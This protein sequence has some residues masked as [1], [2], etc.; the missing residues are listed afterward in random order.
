MSAYPGSK[1]IFCRTIGL[2]PDQAGMIHL[3]S[4]FKR[5][6]RLI[7][8]A[9]VGSMS[10]RNQEETMPSFLRFLQQN[11]GRARGEKGIIHC[12]SYALGTL[13]FKALAR[14]RPRLAAA[15]PA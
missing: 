12:N 14:H 8:L 5:D 1:R 4:V 6:H 2:D 15:L 11:H 3:G 13:I 7:H 10:K 9:L